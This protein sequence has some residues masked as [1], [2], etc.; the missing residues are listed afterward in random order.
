MMNNAGSTVLDF[1]EATFADDLDVSHNP[2][3]HHDPAPPLPLMAGTYGIRLKQ[4]G[5]KRVRDE[6]GQP[7]DELV[8]VKN[9]KGEPTYPVIEVKQ[10]EVV[11]SNDAGELVG[12]TAY[13]FQEF[14]TKP[15]MKK[16]FNA[17]GIEYPYNALAAIIRSHDAT[18][19]FRGLNEGLAVFKRLL[20][21][22]AIFFV[23]TDW[24]AED[25]AWT[26]D[27][28]KLIDTLQESGE[29]DEAEA[30]KRRNE[31]RYKQGQQEGI[32][33]FVI[34]GDD[35]SKVLLPTWTSP[36]GDDIEARV[37]IREWVSTATL[38]RV[39]LGPRKI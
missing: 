5:L 37:F 16:D 12:R 29:I 36:G 26:R 35:G 30:K 34:K 32:A 6:H 2:E 28:V 11:K 23:R 7:T 21:D 10:F 31:V 22:G 1:P 25:R 13:P 3:D 19:P 9:A 8:L 39:K 24:K 27:Q 33:K 18:I 20:S 14:G 38:D 4:A 15:T 17:G